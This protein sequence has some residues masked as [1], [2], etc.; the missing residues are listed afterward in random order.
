MLRA[1]TAA[2]MRGLEERFMKETGCPSLL[3]MEHAAM[4]LVNA[5]PP[6]SGKIIFLCGFG[7]NGGDGYAAARLHAG[8]AEVWALDREKLTGDALLN[9]QLLAHIR[10]DVKIIDLADPLLPFPEDAGLI[11]DA[12]FG[13][14]LSRPITGLAAQVVAQA[15]QSGLPI[16]AC[17]I[18]SGVDGT[19]GAGL[20]AAIRAQKTVTFHA[21]KTG[22]YLKD[23]VDHTG[24]IAAMDIGIPS[25]FN[26]ADMIQIAE[27]GDLPSLRPPRPRFS[28][29]GDYGRVLILA[30]SEGMAGAAAICAA[31]AVK[32]GAGLVTVACDAAVLPIVQMLAPNATCLKLPD[33]SQ[34]ATLLLMQAAKKADVL[35]A[36]PGLGS[37]SRRLPLLKALIASGKPCVWDA[38]ALNLF[39]L[40]SDLMPKGDQNVYT[41]HP[42]EAE[43]LLGAPAADAVLSV[44]A[45]QKRLGGTFILKGATSVI[46][47]GNQMAFNTVGTP[48]LAKGGSGDALT[49]IIAALL[50]RHSPYEAARLGCLLHG[51]AGQRAAEECGENAVDA[52]ALVQAIP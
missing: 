16:V 35:A 36:G 7:Q 12:L 34:D 22:L 42:G 2:Q 46:Y 32:T 4:A 21:P 30:G 27:K 33:A 37:D 25:R 19:A 48:A 11:V 18:P 13:T 23:A 50:K 10:P 39:S 3:L 24:E 6:V 9:Q 45:L 8:K 52:A 41:P 20:G 43:R 17:D 14:G 38:D 29:K 26:P 44:Q 31:A 51:M 1:V 47:D 40:H 49:G 5:L 15:N 28:H